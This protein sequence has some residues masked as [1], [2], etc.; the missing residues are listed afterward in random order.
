MESQKSRSLSTTE[1]SVAVRVANG[2]V[3]GIARHWL[4]LFNMGWALYVGLPFLAPILMQMGW[5][6]PAHMIYV[7]YSFFCHQL[8]DHSYF[9]FGSSWA[10]SLEQLHAYGMDAGLNLFEQRRFIGNELAGYKVALCQRDVAIYG[11]VLAAGLIYGLQ[12]RGTD[13]PPRALNWKIYVLLL[14]PIA[15]DGGTQLVGLRESNW[16]LRSFTGALF[17]IASVWLAYPHVDGAMR[18]LWR[19]T[20]SL[21]PQSR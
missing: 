17:G 4:L 19:E 6:A 14:L 11:S 7:V 13:R 9:L 21:P 18:E 2:I 5:V 12:T 20:A 10:P 15:L 16:L 8:P 3:T 1:P